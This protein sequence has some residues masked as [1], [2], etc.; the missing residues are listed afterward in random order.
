[1]HGKKESESLTVRGYSG[2]DRIPT[3]FQ[4]EDKEWRADLDT[5]TLKAQGQRGERDGRRRGA[6][7]NSV[8][9]DKRNRKTSSE[10]ARH[11]RLKISRE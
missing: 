9:G 11:K 5:S 1:M 6:R 2:P 7:R 4:D 8:L 3:E 10:V